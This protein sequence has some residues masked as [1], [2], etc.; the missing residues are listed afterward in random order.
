MKNVKVTLSTNAAAIACGVIMLGLII[1]VAFSYREMSSMRRDLYA[2]RSDY[3]GL[4]QPYD[5]GYVDDGTGTGD[6][7]G[8]TEPIFEIISQ[9]V[10]ELRVNDDEATAMQPQ[11]ETWEQQ[12]K[13]AKIRTVEVKITNDMEYTYAY[14]DSL[15]YTDANGVIKRSI[16]LHPDDNKNTLTKNYTSLE[17]APGG[18]ATVFLYFL[19]D[20]KEIEKLY[21][22]DSMNAL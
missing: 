14:Y 4:N 10:A 17:L 5:D 16:L 15:G 20:G 12:Y 1:A 9:N 22:S 8:N 7:V 13:T 11:D 19:D 6:D 2:V 18:T 21:N 3:Y